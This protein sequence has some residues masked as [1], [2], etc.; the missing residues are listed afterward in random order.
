M[1]EIASDG[2]LP[3]KLG[4]SKSFI[5]V[6]SIIAIS[7]V[8]IVLIVTGTLQLLLEFGSITF[9]LISLRMAITNFKIR[10]KTNSNTFVTALAIFALIPGSILIL[11]YEFT[12]ALH[13]MIYILVL[14]IIIGIGSV[15]FARKRKKKSLLEKNGKKDKKD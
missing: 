15:M 7:F 3:K 6:Y 9:L 10:K 13:Q 1:Q 2:Y 5:P 4:E 8:A 14:Y 12:Y 11:W